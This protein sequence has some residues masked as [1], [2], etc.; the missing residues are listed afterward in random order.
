MPRSRRMCWMHATALAHAFALP[1]ASSAGHA[2]ALLG[3][4]ASM[5]ERSLACQVMP[6]SISRSIAEDRSAITVLL[7]H[8][9]A[10]RGKQRTRHVRAAEP[11]PRRCVDD[12]ARAAACRLL[13][14]RRAPHARG[15]CP[16]SAR[17]ALTAEALGAERGVAAVCGRLARGV[18][19]RAPRTRPGTRRQ[20]RGGTAVTTPSRASAEIHD[21]LPI[22]RIMCRSWS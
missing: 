20:I 9:S 17:R 5:P 8:A 21:L 2:T 19:A 7:H 13:P 18:V 16:P 4:L 6:R 14:H 22:G 11:I 12:C 15:C 10:I 3:R 1:P